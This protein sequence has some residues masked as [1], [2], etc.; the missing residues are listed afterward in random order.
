MEWLTTML[1]GFYRAGQLQIFTLIP[2]YLTEQ[3]TTEMFSRVAWNGERFVMESLGIKPPGLH[4]G[5]EI[6]DATK[7]VTTDEELRGIL[8]RYSRPG[9]YLENTRRLLPNF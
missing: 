5:F 2:W 8:Q 4:D 1:N 7:V 6:Y 3:R 9:P